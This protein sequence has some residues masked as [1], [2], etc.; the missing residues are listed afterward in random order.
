VQLRGG[1][2]HL[3]IDRRAFLKIGSSVIGATALGTGLYGSE[4][5]RHDIAVEAHTVALRGLGDGLH[6]LRIAHFSDL[7]YDEFSEPYYIR[8]VV[9]RVN[10]L[11]P[12]VVLMTGD[13]VSYAPLPPSFGARHSGPCAALVAELECPIR[14][15]VMGNHDGIV[16]APIV[17]DALEMHGVRVLHNEY[18]PLEKDGARLWLGGTADVLEGNAQIGPT[19]PPK[20]I[21][22]NE[23]VLIMVHEPD[24]ADEVA[25]H[26]GV[27][28]MLSGHTHGGQIRIP[29]MR[30][31]ALPPM[32]QKYVEGFFQVGPTLLHVN[33]GIGTVG[34][35]VRFLCRPEITIFTLSA[36]A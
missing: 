21:R 22:G 27:D 36:E 6:G 14:Y 16:G 32:G 2:K 9:H 20:R 25:K 13:F 1:C 5:E 18:L 26:G 29:F 23:P 30:P 3:T 12:D 8:E 33:R 4:F 35:P 31:R 17:T 7:H 15:A 24:F 34:V 19:V 11:K 10:A 28:L